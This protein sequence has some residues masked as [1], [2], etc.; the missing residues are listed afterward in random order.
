MV[1]ADAILEPR[2]GPRRL[3]AAEEPVVHEQRERVIHG[4]E[5]DRSDL[6]ADQFGDAIRRDVRRGGDDA[7]DREPLCG[8]VNA[9]LSKQRGRIAM[10]RPTVAQIWNDSNL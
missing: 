4:L 5:G 7:H 8:D 10:H 2:G 1:V 6:G 3:N 9:A